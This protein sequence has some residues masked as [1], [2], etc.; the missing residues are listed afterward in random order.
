MYIYIQPYTHIRT[1]V[2]IHR[3]KEHERA[4]I[5]SDCGF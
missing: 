1:I 4:V 5:L 3:G 2:D